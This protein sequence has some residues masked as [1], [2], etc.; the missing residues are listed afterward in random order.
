MYEQNTA[1]LVDRVEL[2][3]Y[4][5]DG[6]AMWETVLVRQV[7]TVDVVNS[8]DGSRKTVGIDAF[9]RRYWLVKPTAPDVVRAEDEGCWR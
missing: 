9:R 3:A 5:T 6:T 4:Y 2:N 8:L 7:G 1:P